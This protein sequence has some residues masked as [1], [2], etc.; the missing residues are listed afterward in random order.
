MKKVFTCLSLLAMI[1]ISCEKE[2]P[3]APRACYK[4]TETV[5]LSP[6]SATA[7]G[8]PQTTKSVTEYCN[9]TAADAEDKEKSRTY[10]VIQNGYS[11]KAETSAKCVRKW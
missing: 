4:C 7:A 6:H 2:G 10:T 9:W 11:L 5:T 8:Y 3:D 1:L